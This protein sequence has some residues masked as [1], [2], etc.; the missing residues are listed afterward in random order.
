MQRREGWHRV[1]RDAADEPMTLA[2]FERHTQT[3]APPGECKYC[4]ER[5]RRA[6][7]HMAALRERGE[8]L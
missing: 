5:R 7:R 6:R 3:Y 4:D 2:S 1:D 8:D